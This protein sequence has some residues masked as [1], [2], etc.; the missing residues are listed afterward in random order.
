MYSGSTL[1]FAGYAANGNAIQS[2][3]AVMLSSYPSPA[4]SHILG[5]LFSLL[6]KTLNLKSFKIFSSR[7]RFSKGA[8][9]EYIHA[10]T[11]RLVSNCHC[12]RATVMASACITTLIMSTILL[13]I[14]TPFA[15]HSH[16]LCISQRSVPRILPLP[17]AAAVGGLAE[18]LDAQ[19]LFV[20]DAASNTM[21]SPSIALQLQPKCS[22]K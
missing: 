9:R 6:L 15:L 18:A 22:I 8:I 10:G 2:P 17:A 20:S 16:P 14:P 5:P 4:G 7:Q 11:S 19:R 1:D 21:C 13:I 3:A 12:V